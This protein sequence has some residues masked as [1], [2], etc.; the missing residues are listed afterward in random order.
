MRAITKLSLLTLLV[1]GLLAAPLALAR[2]AD[3]HDDAADAGKA[4]GE[5]HRTNATAA[6]DACANASSSSAAACGA[7]DHRA[8]RNATSDRE[9][10]TARRAE[11]QVARQAWR[12][13]ASL[14]RD[15]WHEN[16]TAIRERCQAAELDRENATKEERTAHSQCIK[17]GYSSWREANM[18]RITALRDAF[19][20][21]LGARGHL[22][23]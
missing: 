14:V 16:A 13:N 10:A 1:V 12:E 4:R 21:F 2:G 22:G 20:A 19:L 11:I 15:S 9:N 7:D 6:G 18:A 23:S 17:T 5:E 8:E 3:D